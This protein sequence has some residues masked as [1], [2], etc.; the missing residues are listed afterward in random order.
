M[1]QRRAT[2]SIVNFDNYVHNSQTTKL[3]S[4][5]CRM[6]RV[7]SSSSLPSVARK[8]A[9]L[10]IRNPGAAALIEKLVDDLLAEIERRKL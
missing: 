1:S 6:L 8:S 5:K 2:A 9:A 10:A 7:D 3:A 4:V